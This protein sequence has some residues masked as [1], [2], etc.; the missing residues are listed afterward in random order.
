VRD[1]C[2]QLFKR[3]PHFIFKAVVIISGADTGQGMSQASLG[4]INVNTSA[5]QH[6]SARAPQIMQPPISDR[7]AFA[8]LALAAAKADGAL[9]AGGEHVRTAINAGLG[10]DYR[11]KA[12]R[13]NGRARSTLFL[14]RDAGRVH[15]SP[16]I[17]S[18][19]SAAASWRRAPVSK[20]LIRQSGVA[21]RCRLPKLDQ[22]IVVQNPGAAVFRCAV[23]GHATD[24][25]A[26][27]IVVTHR[28]QFAARRR[29]CRAKSAGRVP[30]VSSIWSIMLLT[31][32][33]VRALIWICP[34]RG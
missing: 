27:E 14:F 34:M 3:E 21:I 31:C 19:V 18:H 4:N 29:Y 8:E 24:K 15:T 5:A 1:Q 33:R 22:F 10:R 25:R 20:N 9:A 23:A 7:A 11:H 30:D 16:R 17:S 32:E 28:V 26:A 2:G 13:L 6:R 12:V